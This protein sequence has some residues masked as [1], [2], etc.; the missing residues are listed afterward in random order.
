M[1]PLLHPQLVNAPFQD[2]GLLVDCLFDRR[3]LLFDLGDLASVPPK[4]LLRV[5]HAFV[6]HTHMDHFGGFDHLLRVCLGRE[7]ALHLF[8]PAGFIDR[9]GHKIAAYTWNLVESAPTDFVVIATELSDGHATTAR[10]HSRRAFRRDE[11]GTAPVR[12]G[13]ILAEPALV[14]RAVELDHGIPCL[15]F[16]VE[17]PVHI[18]LWKDRIVDMGLGVG[19]WLQDL[20]RAVR[21]GDP[22]DAPIQ[23]AWTTAAGGKAEATVPL[24]RLR[25]TA[26]AT[27]PGQKIAYVVDAAY[28]EAN[29]T[30]II[31]LA[32]GADVLFIESPFLDRD[33]DLAAA[34]RHLTAGQAGRLARAAGVR[35][36][37]T[38]HFSPRYQ[39]QHNQES[40]DQLRREAAEAW[41]GEAWQGG[42][43]AHP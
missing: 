41:Q 6:S 18:N 42:A 16:A 17:E 5:S 12:D 10:F 31:G 8:G 28:H 22:D 35:K 33:A 38:F 30:R 34:R 25:S 29:A 3:A 1:R 43:E 9:V 2:P 13:V 20:K 15:A 11:A 32:R 39:G 37:V 27:V 19:P 4:K 36:L 21:R 14:V 7:K 24:G 40:A 26:L 23:A